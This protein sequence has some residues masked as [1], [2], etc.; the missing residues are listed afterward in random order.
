MRTA[1]TSR[2]RGDEKEEEKAKKQSHFGVLILLIRISCRKFIVKGRESHGQY[3]EFKRLEK[4]GGGL[5]T[6][7]DRSA[8]A[9]N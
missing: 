3:I 8:C 7:E 4:R 2:G 5:W 1:V 6:V 9:E